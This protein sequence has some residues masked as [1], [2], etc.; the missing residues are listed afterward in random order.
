M[1]VVRPMPDA[2]PPT[3]VAEL[4]KTSTGTAGHI[5]DAGFMDCGIV[6][7]MPGRKIV[8]TAIT[9]RVTVPD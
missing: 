5:L 3:L 6:A 4:M 1:F 2:L 8:G 7:R 9:V